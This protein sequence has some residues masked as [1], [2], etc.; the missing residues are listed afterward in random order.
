MDLIDNHARRMRGFPGAIAFVAA[1]ALFP[2]TSL[3]VAPPAVLQVCVRRDERS[4][5]EFN[6]NFTRGPIPLPAG[7]IFDI[8]GHTFGGA[9]DP[10]DG[11]HMRT[12]PIPEWSGISKAEGERRG[13]ALLED[14]R[15]DRRHRTGLV[16]LVAVR[17]TRSVP[18]A[19]VPVAAVASEE[20]GWTVTPAFG[21]PSIYYQTFGVIHDGKLNTDWTA[22]PPALGVPAL[23]GALNRVLRGT[24]DRVVRLPT[25]N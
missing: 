1:A 12:G 2:V 24:T 7:V 14:A 23:G 18:C 17:L 19:L 8:A 25:G 9:A 21:D 6:E 3:A 22:E 16:T 11:L 20:W 13:E 15:R 4:P 5:V 10:L